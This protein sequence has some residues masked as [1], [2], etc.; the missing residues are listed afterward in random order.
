MRQRP[1]GRNISDNPRDRDYSGMLNQGEMTSGL[2]IGHCVALA[3][4]ALCAVV[5]TVFFGIHV[6][7]NHHGHHHDD[8]LSQEVITSDSEY[9]IT[10]DNFGNCL[11]DVEI[12]LYRLQRTGD[13][14]LLYVQGTCK[15]TSISGTSLDVDLDME[16]FP[17]RFRC[18]TGSSSD[19]AAV[20]G[21][22]SAVVPGQDVSANLQIEANS[23]SD[24]I[25]IDIDFSGSV[26]DGSDVEFS[27]V[28]SYDVGRCS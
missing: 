7:H 2:K 16:Q 23:N 20:M 27:I 14:V 11:D 12:D 18:P 5:G 4:I 17:K 26:P 9:N 21:T 8:V 25:D 15:N 6:F 28:L 3:V 24:Q 10:N 13:F 19:D 22:G 1:R